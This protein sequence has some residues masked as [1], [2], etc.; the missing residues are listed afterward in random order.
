MIVGR[1]RRFTDNNIYVHAWHGFNLWDPPEKRFFQPSWYK[2]SGDNLRTRHVLHPGSGGWIA[3]EIPIQLNDI[4]VTGFS[5][6]T[7]Y[8]LPGKVIQPLDTIL[9]AHRKTRRIPT[10]YKYQPD[11]LKKAWETEV[12]QQKEY[13]PIN[14]DWGR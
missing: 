4:V 9:E 11:K 1:I 14:E 2:G 5:L 12:L 3:W 6:T 7:G 13:E 10:R 8:K